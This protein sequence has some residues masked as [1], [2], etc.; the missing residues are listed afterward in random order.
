MSRLLL[1]YAPM[2][3]KV[4]DVP[5]DVELYQLLIQLF[6]SWNAPGVEPKIPSKYSFVI[7]EYERMHLVMSMLDISQIYKAATI[8]LFY[9][10]LY[11]GL[12]QNELESD[13]SLWGAKMQLAEVFHDFILNVIPTGPPLK[14]PQ[15]SDDE[16]EDDNEVEIVRKTVKAPHISPE[17][18][19]T[20]QC[21]IIS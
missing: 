6:S 4:I 20:A 14:S 18:I 10:P 3:A 16:D 7:N 8:E 5:G 2:I 15:Y 17:E 19:E 13:K 11:Q 12:I 21:E 9:I 1:E